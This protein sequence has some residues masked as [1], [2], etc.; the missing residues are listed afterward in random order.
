MTPPL[1]PEAAALEAFTGWY[2]SEEPVGRRPKRNVTSVGLIVLEH[3]KA[4]YPLAPQHFITDGGGQVR[5]LS[6]ANIRKILK[7][8]GEVRSFA[9]EGARTNRGSRG[10]AER[11]A[12]TLNAVGGVAS[13]S[14]AE[15]TGIFD[16]LQ[17][18]LKDRAAEYLDRDRLEFEFVPAKPVPE[19]IGDILRAANERRTAGP[20]AQHLVGAKLAVRFRGQTIPN[21]SF[22]TADNQTGRAGDFRFG[23]TVFHVTVAPMPDVFDKCKRNIRDGLR[24]MLLVRESQIAAAKQ[25]AEAAGLTTKLGISSIEGFVGQNLEEMGEFAKEKIFAVMRVLLETYNE[26]VE[27]A[28]AGGQSLQIELPEIL[29]GG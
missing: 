11:L 1:N 21:H 27:E 16:S 18:W 20:V 17:A 25:M 28:E 24:A 6:G 29:L 14:P 13:L 12:A 26:R 8:H 7:A 19:I 9:R 5:L 4:N 10:I 23:E 15:R 22:T 3:A 2:D